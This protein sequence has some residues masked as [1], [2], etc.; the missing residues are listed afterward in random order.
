MWA[1]RW[2]FVPVYFKQ[3]FYPFVQTTARSEGTNAVFK[4]NVSCTYS[5]SSFLDE[6]DRIGE[7]IQE[8]QKNHDS[9]TRRTKATLS[10]GYHFELQAARLYNRAIFF[11]FQKEVIYL[12]RFNV[13]ET[14]PNRSYSVYK[15][16]T[17][18]SR[19]FR[20]R[21]YVV[22]LNLP[23]SKFSCICC[24]FQK[25]GLLCA[26]VLRVLVHLNITELPEK[27]FI[28]RWRPKDKKIKRNITNDIPAE[29]TGDNSQMRYNIIMT[30]MTGHQKL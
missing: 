14:I 18:A 19:E 7:A 5:V 24:K 20:T 11:K 12:T 30:K 6:Y 21:R 25:D 4:D 1:N 26:H 2:R 15:S 28:D 9:V 3:C 13:E 16:E 22:T 29:F 10:S 27:Y 17:H 8:N 23:N